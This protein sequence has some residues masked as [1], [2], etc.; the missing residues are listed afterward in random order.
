ML[1]NL[2]K[3]RE[4]A[5][6]RRAISACE[7]ENVPY[8]GKYGGSG[9]RVCTEWRESFVKFL[10]DMGKI[11][12]GCNS[13]RLHDETKDFCKANCFWGNTNQGRKALK[14]KKPAKK[15]KKFKDPRTICLVLESELLEYIKS[16]ALAKSVE[17]RKMV[18]PNDLIRQ[19]LYDYFKPPKQLDLFKDK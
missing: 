12:K 19:A 6:W 7:N 4:Y 8:Y 13:L 3:T 2:S 18:E 5:A 15:S 9:I 16:N 14:G 1:H 10:E 17:G 11:P